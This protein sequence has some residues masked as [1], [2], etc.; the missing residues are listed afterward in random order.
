ME[1]ER[2]RRHQDGRRKGGVKTAGHE[3]N[4]AVGY[5][6]GGEHRDEG[7]VRGVHEDGAELRNP[8]MHAEQVV[9][10]SDHI[11]GSGRPVIGRNW[12]APRHL[13]GLPGVVRRVGN[14]RQVPQWP[15]GDGE[16]QREPRADDGREAERSFRDSA[17]ASLRRDAVPDPDVRHRKG[18]S[19]AH[20]RTS[21]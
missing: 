12:I 15:E 4:A 2:L 7:D 10:G 17:A 16:A 8:R 14:E 5:E 13:R 3:R 21:R 1:R 18:V 20:R 11:R 6:A 19:P 9:E